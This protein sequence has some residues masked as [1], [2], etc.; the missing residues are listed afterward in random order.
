MHHISTSLK[1][2]LSF[3]L[4]FV[5]IACFSQKYITV[6]TKTADEL[7]RDVF[8]G[9]QNASCITV[10]N[11]SVNGWQD[12]GNNPFSFGYFE[13]GTLPFDIEKEIEY[14]ENSDMPGKD[15]IIKS[16]RTASSN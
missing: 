9:S 10:S 13:K 15:K 14:L 8:I 16:L 12:Y 11:I 2:L 4:A 6:T 7:V 3:L 5:F 1:N